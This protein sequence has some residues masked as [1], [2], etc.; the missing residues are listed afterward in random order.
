VEA[1]QDAPEDEQQLTADKEAMFKLQ[2]QK[3][4][5]AYYRERAPF[6]KMMPELGLEGV[7]IPN[8]EMV[9]TLLKRAEVELAEMENDHD[10]EMEEDR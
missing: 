2:E 7:V 3:L 4:N 10:V 1:E 5:V 8:A 6:Q 9:G